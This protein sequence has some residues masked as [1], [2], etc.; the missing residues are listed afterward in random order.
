[1]RLMPR[2]IAGS[3]LANPIDR[4]SRRRIRGIIDGATS[5]AAVGAP[6]RLMVDRSRPTPI[7]MEG[8]PLIGPAMRQVEHYELIVIMPSNPPSALCPPSPPV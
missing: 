4:P 8:A 5:S 6:T 1:M 2:A 3:G 7:G